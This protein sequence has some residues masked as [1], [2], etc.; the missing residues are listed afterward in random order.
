ML[1]QDSGHNNSCCL[2]LRTQRKKRDLR[3][4]K[5]AADACHAMLD[6]PGRHRSHPSLTSLG[7][8]LWPCKCLKEESSTFGKFMSDSHATAV[9][10]A[11]PVLINRYH[12][13]WKAEIGSEILKGE[14]EVKT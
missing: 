8:C 12:H 9:P 6:L 7:R 2:P 10:S 4:V 11:A 5:G 3:D 1:V 14:G 13:A